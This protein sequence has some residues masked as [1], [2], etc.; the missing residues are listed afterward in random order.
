MIC[1]AP[2]IIDFLPSWIFFSLSAACRNPAIAKMP[3]DR[4]TINEVAKNL[5]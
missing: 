2:S 3:I 5:L 1:F 4:Q